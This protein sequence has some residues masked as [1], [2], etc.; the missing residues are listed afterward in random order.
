MADSRVASYHRRVNR[1]P[2]GLAALT[3]SGPTPETRN[4]FPQLIN[5]LENKV[6]SLQLRL[7]EASAV[8]RQAIQQVSVE[9]VL[10]AVG[11]E[12]TGRFFRLS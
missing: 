10:D 1:C 6:N 2:Q 8:F 11:E 12:H 5:D 7:G 3:L 9:D 4:N